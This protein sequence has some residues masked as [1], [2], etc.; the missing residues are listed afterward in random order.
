MT[1]ASSK[2]RITQI[3]SQEVK[4][5]MGEGFLEVTGEDTYEGSE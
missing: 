1:L 3:T 2:A 4:E 5:T